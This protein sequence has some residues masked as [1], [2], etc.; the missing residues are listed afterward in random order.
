MKLHDKERL[1]F[2][3][4][5][6]SEEGLEKTVAKLFRKAP[7]S[8]LKEF[9]GKSDIKIRSYKTNRKYFL[10]PLVEDSEKRI[11]LDN[12]PPLF[13]TKKTAQ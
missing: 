1:C 6:D 2:L 11:F 13:T 7:K 9:P 3:A 12:I 5:S 8:W 4:Q 10:A